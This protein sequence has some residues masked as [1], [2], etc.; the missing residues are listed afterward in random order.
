L[1]AR[2]REHIRDQIDQ[3]IRKPGDRLPSENELAEAFRVSRITVKQAM[4]ALAKEGLVYRIQGRGTFVADG[5]G[6]EPPMPHPAARTSES[7]LHWA[8]FLVP[9]LDS[10][11]TVHLLKGIEG[12]LSEAGYRLMVCRTHHSPERERE[13][14]REM[15]SSGAEGIIVFPAEGESYSEDIL[16][17]TLDRYPIVV[18]DRYLKGVE[19]NCVCSDHYGGAYEATAH[20]L[21]LGHRKIAFL[22]APIDGTTSLEDRL[23]GYKHALADALLPV[24]QRL[25][26]TDLEHDR[27]VG[28]FRDN[29]DVTG[30]FAANSGIGRKAME[31]IEQAGLRIPEE[32]SVVF[33]DSF[34][35]SAGARIP[36]TAVVQ[37]EEEIGKQAAALL[38]SVIRE[39]NRERRRIVLPACLTV[40]RSTAPPARTQG[41][42]SLALR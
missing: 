31:A 35:Y 26:V 15:V 42:A 28:F 13:L 29:R 6:G 22:S 32:V 41:A 1:Y 36:P 30:V 7:P 33:F 20:L 23:E 5:T 24:E 12:T 16:R 25:I 14:M 9:S 19:T 39:P 37:Q 40:G 34:E 4:A 10:S 8:A 17:L 21:G 27:L 38:L 2:I 11:Y 18:L 3:G